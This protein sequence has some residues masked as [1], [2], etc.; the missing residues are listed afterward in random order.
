[1]KPKILHIDIET[2]PMLVWAWGLYNQNISIGQIE[3][4][5][6]ILCWAAKWHG[7]E[8]IYSDAL[9]KA[10][11]G[12]RHKPIHEKAIVESLW[13][14]LDKADIVVGHNAD[15]FDVAKVNAKFFE[16]GLKPP[17]PFK[18][19]DTLKA[20]RANF[21]FSANRLNYISQLIDVG[22]KIK[23]DFDLWL[24]VMIGVPEACDKMMEYN[25]K[26]VLLLEEIYTAL[27]PWITNHP[28][29][30]VYSEENETVCPACGSTHINYRGYA[31]TA[32]SKFRRFV[33]KDCGHWGR[34]AHNELPLEKRKGLARNVAK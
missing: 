16:Y 28:N 12:K 24:D 30:G 31:Y 26:D 10:S 22:E 1:M 23:T 29:V 15:K 25:I 32:T 19:V 7:E 2:A 21:R 8:I 5:W 20:A 27:R 3:K 14:L 18:V 17:S 11:K 9:W 6:Y 33:C 4:D 13:V 34:S